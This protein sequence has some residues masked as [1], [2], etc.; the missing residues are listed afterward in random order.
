MEIPQESPQNQENGDPMEKIWEYIESYL[1]HVQSN[2]KQYLEIFEESNSNKNIM[3]VIKEKSK[4]RPWS[5]YTFFLIMS[6]IEPNNKDI[7][8]LTQLLSQNEHSDLNKKFLNK[9]S[10]KS[11]VSSILKKENFMSKIKNPKN[12][13][14]VVGVFLVLLIIILSIYFYK[15]RGISSNFGKKFSL[16]SSNSV[17]SKESL[18]DAMDDIGSIVSS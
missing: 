5:L 12:I 17:I 9:V 6:T 14:I 16:S 7:Q 4:D 2:S 11:S 10:K 13:Y 15:S 1:N 3:E 18:K 8:E